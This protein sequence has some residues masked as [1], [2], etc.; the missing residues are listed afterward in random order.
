MANEFIIRE[1]FF[2]KN[3]AII[4]GSLIVTS[5]ITASLDTASFAFTSS[6]STFALSASITTNISSAS[7]SNFT[8]TSSYSLQTFYISGSLSASILPKQ[9]TSIITQPATA[10]VGG[11]LFPFNASS[12]YTLALFNTPTN[13][14]G[15]VYLT[16]IA[17]QSSC[18]V[19]KLG[20]LCNTAVVNP[21]SIRVGIYSNSS[22]MLPS[23]LLTSASLTGL[24]TIRRVYTS[25]VSD[26]ITLQKDEIYWLG[27]VMSGSAGA[28]SQ[29]SYATTG[30]TSGFTQWFGYTQNK[31]FNPLLGV[32]TPVSTISLRQIAY[33][34]TSSITHLL[35]TSLSPTASQYGVLSY[36]DR[37]TTGGTSAATSPIP[38]F[39][40]Y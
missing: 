23:T 26:N 4:T 5:G 12:I 10:S 25:S 14:Q 36:N 8:E 29:N 3:Q 2:S 1:G 16:P 39:I 35:P 7:Y 28:N 24:T 38:P 37:T 20:V 31:L 15:I 33:Y 17:I 6:Y 18:I 13:A 27:M 34:T 22:N 9:I 21:G 30:Y 19:Q 11:V 32:Y 40:F